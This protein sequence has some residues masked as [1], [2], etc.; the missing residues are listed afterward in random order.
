MK[1]YLIR[2]NKELW[3]THVDLSF[4]DWVKKEG[5]GS[6]AIDQELFN[7]FV[8]TYQESL[9]EDFIEKYKMEETDRSLYETEELAYLQMENERL[10]VLLKDQQEKAF[11]EYKLLQTSLHQMSLDA[12]A[13]SNYCAQLAVG[14]NNKKEKYKDDVF[15]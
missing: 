1:H 6:D 2:N 12:R 14:E 11:K 7:Y 15:E 10:K 13:I 9:E 4:G 8:T 5:Y 3:D